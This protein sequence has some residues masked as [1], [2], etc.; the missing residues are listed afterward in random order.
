MT[1][2]SSN[3]A[4]KRWWATAG[5]RHVCEPW[6]AQPQDHPKGSVHGT[7]TAICSDRDS[8]YLPFFTRTH[9]YVL[10]S[11]VGLMQ[12]TKDQALILK[13]GK[14]TS[15][16]INPN[17]HPRVPGAFGNWESRQL[18]AHYAV[19]KRKKLL[20]CRKCK[21][22]GCKKNDDIAKKSKSFTRFSQLHASI[23]F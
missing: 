16:E 10:T 5:F 22:I 9:L 17:C 19:G 12:K 15:Q 23:N 20:H 1:E 8:F 7:E 18:S 3:T 13:L 14:S 6:Q 2:L 4:Y 11:P 21:K